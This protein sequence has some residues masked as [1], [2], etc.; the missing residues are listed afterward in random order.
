MFLVF[1]NK[2]IELNSK[3]LKRYRTVMMSSLNFVKW[4]WY[5]Q[6]IGPSISEYRWISISGSVWFYQKHCRFS[7]GVLVSSCST[8]EGSACRTSVLY[9]FC[10]TECLSFKFQLQSC[11][12][13]NE[14]L[15]H[16]YFVCLT[17]FASLTGTIFSDESLTVQYLGHLLQ[18]VLQLVQRYR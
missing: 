1:R 16:R 8:N 11:L 5:R 15:V 6:N 13:D 10:R 17:Q 18:G 9:S 4:H 7:T 3:V 14:V 12:N 2:W